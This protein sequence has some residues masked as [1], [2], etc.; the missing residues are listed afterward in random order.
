MNV[1]QKIWI[2]AWFTHCIVTRGMQYIIVQS[3]YRVS[4]LWEKSLKMGNLLSRINIQ[5][6]NN[7]VE[8]TETTNNY[9]YPPKTG[10]I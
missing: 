4:C 3:Y 2:F 6:N 10:K 9:K 5:L 8:E 1:E 7:T